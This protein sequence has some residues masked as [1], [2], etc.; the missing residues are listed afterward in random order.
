MYVYYS[1]CFDNSAM[2]MFVI[3][4]VAFMA[5]R[6]QRVCV[7]M[8]EASLQPRTCSVEIDGNIIIV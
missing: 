3:I 6:S 1:E 4:A 2:K 8:F 5:F 7:C